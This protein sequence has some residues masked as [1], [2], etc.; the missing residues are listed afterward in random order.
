MLSFIPW[1]SFIWFLFLA[2]IVYYLFV[3][4][5]YFRKDILVFAKRPRNGQ[6]MSLNL[7]GSAPESDIPFTQVH[8]LLEDLKKIF[9]E[10]ARMKTM[11]AE[12]VQAIR[13]KMKIYRGISE[14]NVREDINQHILTEVKQICGIDL[15]MEDLNQIWI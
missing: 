12:L 2:V 6:Q 8:E 3:S 14:S 4:F 15:E 9:F 10:A 11:K 13:G 1:S 5:A 7:E